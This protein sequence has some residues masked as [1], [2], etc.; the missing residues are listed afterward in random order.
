MSNIRESSPTVEF[1]VSKS[2]IIA[3]LILICLIPF[4]FEWKDF[5]EIFK[6]FYTVY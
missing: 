1:Y 6:N 2:V 3:Y 5:Q 4:E